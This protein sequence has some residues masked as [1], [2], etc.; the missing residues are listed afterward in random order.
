[1][2]LSPGTLSSQ[3]T[4]LP[5]L[6]RCGGAQPGWAL[7]LRPPWATRCGTLVTCGVHTWVGVMKKLRVRELDRDPREGFQRGWRSC[8]RNETCQG[9]SLPSAHL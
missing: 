5:G 9:S 4:V 8:A 7:S 3:W 2:P 1:M 6:G